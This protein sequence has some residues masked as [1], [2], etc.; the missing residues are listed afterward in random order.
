MEIHAEEKSKHILEAYHIIGGMNKNGN[1]IFR[2][3]VT[4]WNEMHKNGVSTFRKFIVYKNGE[5]DN[6]HI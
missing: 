5:V 1:P 3:C 6:T 2:R 4:Y